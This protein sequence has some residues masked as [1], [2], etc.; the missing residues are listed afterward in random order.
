LPLPLLP[1]VIVIHDGTL[2]T[3]HAQPLGAVTFTEPLPPPAPN[4]ALVGLIE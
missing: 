3:V 4:V 2:L 1:E